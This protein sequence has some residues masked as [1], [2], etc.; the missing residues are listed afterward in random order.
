MKKF[1]IIIFALLACVLN[2]CSPVPVEFADFDTPG[3]D[4]SLFTI[5][6][7]RSTTIGEVIGN[8]TTRATTFE[9]QDLAQRI[10]EQFKKSKVIEIVG[11]Y[12][13]LDR[14]HND[15]VL[16]GKVIIPTS[17]PIQ[18]YVLLSHYTISTDRQCPSKS[19]PLEA[20][21]SD[22]GYVFV[23]PDY[24]GFG[25][26]ASH[27]HPYLCMEQTATNVVDMFMAVRKML[28]GTEY[29]PQYDDIFMMGYSQGAAT[30]MAALSRIEMLGEPVNV[31]AALVGGGPYDLTY[32][33][34]SYVTSNY[35]SYPYAL[36]MVAQGMAMSGDMDFDP[37]E[38]M[39][40]DV[41]SHFDEW[42]NSKKYTMGDIN[43]AL[44]TKQTDKILGPKLMDPTTD[45]A[46]NFYKELNK[47][48]IT[49]F[50]WTPHAPVYMLHSINDDV[51]PFENAT[52]ARS[53]WSGGNIQYNFD[54]YGGHTDA[55]Q[56]FI[57][58][59]KTF[60][61]EGKW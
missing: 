38:L 23:V 52:I 12:H 17:V 29:A 58:T 51:V 57:F 44:G 34:Q 48:S 16:S 33:Y 26:T 56:R 32:T 10:F 14:H 4:Q 27:P 24:E 8:G 6:S 13:T 3:L 28:E 60:L 55:F 36:L 53:K 59:V 1:K 61:E 31:R 2:S 30:T 19:F 45:V 47:N 50:A 35:C 22:L 49:L 37:A 7:V 9:M 25:V 15:I 43:R 46:A 39:T 54:Y 11:T 41:A 18:R 21:L 20:V 5:T 42:I 40:P